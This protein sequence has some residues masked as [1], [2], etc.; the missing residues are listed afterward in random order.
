[1]RTS[2]STVRNWALAATLRL[3][4]L[5]VQFSLAEEPPMNMPP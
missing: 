1:M 5:L 4:R 3:A 2:A